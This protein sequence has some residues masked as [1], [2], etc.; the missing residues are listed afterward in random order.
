ML[1][2]FFVNVTSWWS[3]ASNVRLGINVQLTVS[4][5]HKCSSATLYKVS[6]L[7][8]TNIGCPS[9]LAHLIVKRWE[10]N[11]TFRNRPIVCW[12]LWITYMTVN[13]SWQL[14]TLANQ[15]Y[16]NCKSDICESIP[17]RKTNQTMKTRQFRKHSQ[18]VSLECKVSWFWSRTGRNHIF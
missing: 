1:K 18:R 4:I 16:I 2:Q 5:G 10:L 8:E 14:F 7:G 6:S 12:G 9:L 3:I 13:C 11:P 15:S 17:I